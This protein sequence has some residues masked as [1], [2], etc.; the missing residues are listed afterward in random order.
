MGNKKE[1]IGENK[2][3][4]R[5]GRETGSG[6]GSGTENREESREKRNMESYIPM[7]DMLGKTFGAGLE[8]VLHD[9]S[10]PQSS[11]VYT[12]NGHVTGRKVGQSFDHLVRKVLLDENFSNDYLANYYFYTEDGRLIKSSTVL[13][14]NPDGQVAG[15]LCLNMDTTVL[16]GAMG[17]LS[18][19]LPGIETARDQLTIPENPVEEPAGI[20]E[21]ADQ[22]IGRIIGDRD[23]GKMKRED[24]VAIVRFMDQKGLFLIKGTAQKVAERLGISKVTVYSYLDEVKGSAGEK[25]EE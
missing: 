24:K 2:A 17:L 3:K 10:K 20:V 6:I 1:D 16:S 14:R 4:S 18:S 9:L 25:T 21:I 7:A 13:L 22:L 23:S 12:V 8:V 15:A 5:K 11:V 19:L